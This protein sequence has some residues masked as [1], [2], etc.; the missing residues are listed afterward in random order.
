VQAR[1]LDQPQRPLERAVF[2]TEYVLRH[3]GASHLRS[4]AADLNWV[5]LNLCDVY[6]A[7]FAILALPLVFFY[8]TVKLIVRKLC[9]KKSEVKAKVSKQKKNK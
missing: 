1:V 4:A 7:T 8:Y 5:Q 6:L 2:W 9:C 3:K